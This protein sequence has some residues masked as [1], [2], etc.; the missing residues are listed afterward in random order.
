MASVNECIVREYFEALG[1]MV[2]QP[3]K[4]HVMGRQKRYKEEIDLIV[5][6][7]LI[8]EQR[9][10]ETMLW[11]TNDLSCIARAV[12]GIYGWHTERFYPSMLE[13]IPDIARFT[14][15]ESARISGKLIGTGNAAKILCLP[16]L[17]A[18][19]KMREK[20]LSILKQK[21]IDGV[22]LFPQLLLELINRIAVNRNY[23]K[24]DLLQILRILKIYDLLKDRQLDLFPVKK[25]KR[26]VNCKP[27]TK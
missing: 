13:H 26:Q 11:T 2:S 12:I 1:Y 22:L 15:R 7:P 17:P 27:D 8:S 3:C 19:K 20:T 21:G 6:N 24:S 16:Q 9:I 18:T 10:P 23:E 25:P 14:S 4:Y 5:I